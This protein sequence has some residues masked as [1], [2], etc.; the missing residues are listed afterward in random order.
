[1]IDIAKF[2]RSRSAE[3]QLITYMATVLKITHEGAQAVFTIPLHGCAPLP[4][5]SGLAALRQQ[6]MDLTPPQVRRQSLSV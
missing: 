5:A 1:M 4:K 3:P 6:L 2:S